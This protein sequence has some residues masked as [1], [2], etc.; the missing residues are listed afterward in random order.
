[1]LEPV[2]LGPTAAIPRS[3]DRLGL[4]NEKKGELEMKRRDAIQKMR[5]NLLRRRDAI[6]KSLDL[7]RSQLGTVHDC[8]VGDSVDHALDAEYHEISS[9]LAEVESTEL[10]Q[11]D[12][13][14]Q[15]MATGNYGVCDDCGRNI[16]LAR[17]QA[18]P[19]ATLCIECQRDREAD[20]P[21]ES[22]TTFLVEPGQNVA[23]LNGDASVW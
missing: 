9:Q 18:L 4:R 17:L 20:G 13:A 15:R 22:N 10:S 2:K 8:D 1:M 6:G 14:L 7:T 16:P 19:Y 23:M 5:A 3:E 12:V 11:I 21:S